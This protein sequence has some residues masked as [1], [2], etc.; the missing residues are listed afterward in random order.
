MRGTG[1]PPAPS[2]WMRR[3]ARP[4]K[5]HAERAGSAPTTARRSAPERLSKAG[6]SGGSRPA[7]ATKPKRLNV[8]LQGGGAYGAFTWGVLDGLLADGRIEIVSFSGTSAGAMNA[9]AVAAGLMDAGAEGA[10]A[11]MEAFWRAISETARYYSPVRP[12]PFDPRPVPDGAAS[13]VALD[14]FTRLVSPYQFNPLD[15][16]PLREVLR[17]AVDFKRLRRESP[18]SL[19]IAATEVASGRVRIFETDEVSVDV[20]LASAC[21]PHLH[22][23]VKIGRNHYWDGGYSANPPLLPLL[24]S[25]RAE[26]T[27]I[28]Q[29]DPAK[30]PDLPTNAQAIIARLN[31]IAFNGPLHREVEMIEQI[32]RVASDGFAVGGT[33]RRRVK[34]HRFHHIAAGNLTSDLGGASRLH[35]D[36]QLL[37]QLRERGQAAAVTWLNR[38][39]SAIGRDSTVDL[40]ARFL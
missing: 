7:A 21:L 11:K 35:P 17:S 20:V 39:F 5:G 3:L 26:D 40:A 2:S 13:I 4:K 31:R 32:R 19:H 36:L 33:L 16:N 14:L 12:H 6:D 23:A 10:R 22:Q 34:T 18:V 1:K 25:G 8:A 9:V 30:D 27:L 37:H 38:N 28:V 24:R 15:F 29:I